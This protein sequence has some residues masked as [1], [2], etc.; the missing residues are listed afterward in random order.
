[1]VPP[2]NAQGAPAPASGPNRLPAYIAFGVGGAGVALGAVFGI[3]ALGT[4]STLDNE[5]PGKVCPPSAKSDVDNLSSRATV[6]NIAFAVGAVGVA[7]GVVLLV[8]LHGSDAPKTAMARPP[9]RVTPWI[10]L[11]A[12]G[13]GGTFE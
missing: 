9:V 1:M 4:K 13:L 12:A 11:G 5:C 10:G 8:T 6:S 3:L 2:P 7:A